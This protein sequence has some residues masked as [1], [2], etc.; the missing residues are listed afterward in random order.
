MGN[1]NIKFVKQ[2]YSK[3]RDIKNLVNYIA[4]NGRNKDREIVYEFSARG[5][6]CDSNKAGEQIIKMQGNVNKARQR[7]MFHVVV[8]FEEAHY[9]DA[10]ATASDIA[11]R[12][13]EDYQLVYGI[14]TSTFNP[15][16][17]FGIN[18]VNRKDGTKMHWS[19]TDMEEFNAF[20]KETAQKHGISLRTSREKRYPTF[21]E[22]FGKKQ[23]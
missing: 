6:S 9:D 14:H 11:D 4:G 23:K 19:S 8:S 5:L 20:V 10:Q 7:R 13:F 3:D 2:N 15:H 1:I 22:L 21:E 12:L 17:H 18:R 16:I